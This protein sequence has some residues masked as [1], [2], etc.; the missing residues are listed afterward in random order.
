MQSIY[1]LIVFLGVIFISGSAIAQDDFSQLLNERVQRGDN[2]FSIQKFAENWFKNHPAGKGSGYNQ[3]KRWEYDMLFQIGGDGELPAGKQNG[4][5]AK[6]QQF[7]QVQ[8]DSISLQNTG[9]AWTNLSQSVPIVAGGTNSGAGRVNSWAFTPGSDNVMICTPMGGMWRGIW[10]QFLSTFLWTPYSDALPNPGILQACYNYNNNNIIYAL[11]GGRDVETRRSSGVIKSTD[12][13]LNWQPTALKIKESEQVFVLKMIMHPTNPECLYV[14]TQNRLVRT[15]NGG[16]NWDTV[17]TGNYTDVAYKP[18]STIMYL[19]NGTGL[20]ISDVNGENFIVFGSGLPATGSFNVKIGIT[21]AAPET[22]YL[23]YG[24]GQ[25]GFHRLMRS[26][27]GGSNFFIQSFGN[28]NTNPLGYCDN[29]V[30]ECGYGSLGQLFRNCEIAVSPTNAASVFVGGI[31]V[32]ESDNSGIN[33]TIRAKWEEPNNIGYAHAD[34]HALE[35]RNGFLY[36]GSDGGFYRMSL[37]SKVWLPFTDQLSLAQVYRVGGTSENQLFWGCQDNGLN[38]WKTASYRHVIC[39]DGTSS[40]QAP[41]NSNIVYGSTQKGR[42]AKSSDAG[43][44]F[45]TGIFPPRQL[46]AGSTTCLCDDTT[47]GAWVTPIVISQS[48]ASKLYIGYRQLYKSTNGGTSWTAHALPSTTNVLTAMAISPQDDNVVY[49]ARSSNSLFRTMDGGSTIEELTLLPSNFVISSIAV[50]PAD[51]NHIFVSLGG[52]T[53][54]NKVYEGT[55]NGEGILTWTNITGSLPN[56]PYYTIVSAGAG[57]V[58][59][60]GDV[61]VYYRNAQTTGW[62]FYGTGL[63][64]TSIRDLRIVSGKL[65]AASFGRGVWKTPVFSPCPANFNHDAQSGIINV[66]G[67]EFY[68]ASTSIVSDVSTTGGFGASLVYKS[69][70]FITLK[71]G[72]TATFGTAMLSQILPCNTVGF[73]PADLI[74]IK[75]N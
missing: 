12:G 31:N 75:G 73:S 5:L 25:Y 21:P 57:G 66:N 16:N 72:F 38:E 39:C 58:Y 42:F 20:R 60:G 2:F 70:N 43:V 64:S 1:K 47:G 29:G 74:P 15:Q 24:G 40:V 51:K 22:L 10:V 65:I 71:P 67:Q 33:W 46:G 56:M 59:V 68:Q 13:G 7:L 55:I 37:T 9:A 8:S 34:I 48:N 61:G 52:Y 49:M 18:G 36:C 23:L 27:N 62:I 54:A 44:T 26:T 50:D 41:T 63:P 6:M 11:T 45:P 19:A 28:P 14:L 35:V 32:W 53:T 30:A 69:G 3:Y 4:N 17:V